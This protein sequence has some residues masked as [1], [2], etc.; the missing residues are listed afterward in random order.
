MQVD[1]LDLVLEAPEAEKNKAVEE[2]SEMVCE[3]TVVEKAD[4][5]GKESLDFRHLRATELKNNKRVILQQPGD[6]TEEIRRSNLKSELRK[7]VMKYRHENCD[8][9]GNVSDNNL[10][11]TKLKTMKN[12]KT[13][14]NKEGL[15]CSQTDKTGKLTLDTLENVTKKMEKHVKDDKVIDVKK[16]KTLENRLN[17]HMEW[18]VRILQ[19]GKHNNQTRRVKSNLIT[20]DNQ[21]PV[22]RG[23]SK[24]HKKAVDE[25]I[26]PDLRPIMGAIV[27]PNI[28]LSEL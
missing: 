20:K 27:G 6:E 18:W 16:V 23:T 12:L 21:I 2:A 7:V 26:G 3:A 14:I 8:K 22:L 19:P 24:D 15:I 17:S 9:F 25:K 10:S 1:R 4:N 5:P 28:G 11:K 13:R